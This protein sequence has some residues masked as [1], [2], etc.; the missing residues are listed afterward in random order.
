MK[1]RMQKQGAEDALLNATNEK[2]HE[3]T[4]GNEY[5]IM[6]VRCQKRMKRK[7]N[8][9]KLWKDGKVSGIL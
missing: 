6:K 9:T 5:L 2:K 3:G 1:K 7:I 8:M 4:R